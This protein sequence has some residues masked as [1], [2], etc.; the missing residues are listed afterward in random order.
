VIGHDCVVAS[1]HVF[2]HGFSVV[3]LGQ[4]GACATCVI[5]V[6]TK[7][8]CPTIIHVESVIGY[9]GLCGGQEPLGLDSAWVLVLQLDGHKLNL[10]CGI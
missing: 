9:D 4:V 6:E 8:M 7:T 5:V 3:S 10:H 1:L 2:D